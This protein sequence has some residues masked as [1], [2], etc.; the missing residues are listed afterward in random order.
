MNNRLIDIQE[1]IFKEME[2]LEKEDISNDTCS[3][4]IARSNALTNS[5]MTY[6][7]SINTQL[8]IHESAAK[9]GATKA[10]LNT[11]FGITK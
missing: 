4:E 2:R 6:I 11:E 3:N 8:R 1:K 10:S 5:A 9:A 7:K